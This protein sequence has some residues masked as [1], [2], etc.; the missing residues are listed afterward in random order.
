MGT[1]NFKLPFS[2]ENPYFMKI[3]SDFPELW[4]LGTQG[5]IKG[6]TAA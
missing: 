6:Q 5:T 3:W 2:N 4:Q 1:L